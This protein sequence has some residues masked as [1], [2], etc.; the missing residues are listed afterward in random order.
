MRLY[1]NTQY[2]LSSQSQAILCPP[3]AE[4]VMYDH[5]QHSNYS[6]QFNVSVLRFQFSTLLSTKYKEFIAAQISTNSGQGKNYK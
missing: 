4:I 1:T 5:K 3:M 6:Y 2:T